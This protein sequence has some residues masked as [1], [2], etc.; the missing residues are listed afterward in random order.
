MN[1]NLDDTIV[2]DGF[3]FRDVYSDFTIKSHEV[4]TIKK[5]PTGGIIILHRGDDTRTVWI[6]GVHDSLPAK[7]YNLGEDGFVRLLQSAFI[8]QVLE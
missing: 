2:P 8:T 6:K 7:N 1:I 4:H 5:I 3:E